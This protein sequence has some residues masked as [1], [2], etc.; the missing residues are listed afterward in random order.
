QQG[1]APTRGPAQHVKHVTVVPVV[2]GVEAEIDALVRCL[3]WIAFHACPLSRAA[4]RK[5]A[6][7]EMRR[8]HE[9]SDVADVAREGILATP[10][11][12]WQAAVERGFPTTV[13]PWCGPLADADRLCYRF[14]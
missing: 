5:A 10:V 4:G 8:W 2:L 1:R 11:S 13:E 3:P 12:G 14:A 9:R 7:A 6:T